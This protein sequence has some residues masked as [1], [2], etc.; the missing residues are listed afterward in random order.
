MNLHRVHLAG[1][2][3]QPWRNGG[4]STRELLA[5]PQASGWQ[6]RV[7][8]ATIAQD[9]PFSAFPGI[10][11]WFAVLQGAGVLLALPGGEMRLTPQSDALHF[12]GAA[13]P[14]C[15][16][17]GG[18]TDDLNLMSTHGAGR[19]ALWRATPTQPLRGGSRWRGV[20]AAD[21][22]HLRAGSERVDLQAGTLL[23]CDDMA[24]DEWQLPHAT[25]DAQAWCME[26]RA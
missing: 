13:A 2:T 7:S 14:G 3:P 11:R 4:G 20:F 18:P 21:A 19:A 23:W 5:W 6:L 17:L 10:S 8:V 26:L 16:L 22:L 12:D 9:G 25:S 1:V 15:R 24:A